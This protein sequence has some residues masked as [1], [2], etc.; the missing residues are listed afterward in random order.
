M[1]LYKAIFHAE[2]V[3]TKLPTSQTIFGAV[4]TIIKETQGQEA[5]NQYLKSLQT[6]PLFIHSSMLPNDL[7]PMP[8]RNI[9]SLSL[10]NQKVKQAKPENK[11]RELNEFKTYKKIKLISSKVLSD[12][13]LQDDFNKLGKTILNSEDKFSSVDNEILQLKT[14]NIQYIRKNI[15][16][17][18]NSLKDQKQV[19]HSNTELEDNNLFY[20]SEIFAD[21]QQQFAVYFKTDASVDKIASIFKYFEFFGVGEKRSV[22]LNA[23]KLIEILPVVIDNQSSYKYLLS[24]CIPDE[25]IDLYNSY[26]GIQS[27]IYKASNYY[28]GGF[29]TGRY[30]FLEPGSM[31]KVKEQKEFYGKM[32]WDISNGKQVYHYGLGLVV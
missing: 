25:S 11:M 28:N 23:F 17:T 19:F 20:V 26:Y 30:S 5:L 16:A 15:L 14:E 6:D 29:P 2:S 12:Y 4:C 24:D 32:E 13:I 27:H 10:V 3:I 7:F 1:R 21:P 8:R 18:R 22:G 31:L 9:F